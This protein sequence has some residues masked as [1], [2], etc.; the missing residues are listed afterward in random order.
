MTKETHHS[1]TSDSIILN[2]NSLASRLGVYNISTIPK[3]RV[4]SLSCLYYM[5][6]S[7]CN[8]PNGG[9]HVG[10]PICIVQLG[11]TSHASLQ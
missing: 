9:K 7:P 3:S 8:E 6:L 1:R 4:S 10:Y 5:I 11:S 2:I